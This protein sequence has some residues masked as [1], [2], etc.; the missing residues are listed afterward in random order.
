MISPKHLKFSRWAS[1]GSC[2]FA[3]SVAATAYAFG[4][5]SEGLEDALGYTQE[6]IDFIA[7]VGETGLYMAVFCGVFMGFCGPRLTI[8]LGSILV[9]VGFQYLYLATT[10]Q[11]QSS[12]GSVAGMLF[13]SQLGTACI[14]V[15]TTAVC[16]RNFPPEDRGKAA[17]LAKAY[18]GVSSAIIAQLYAGFFD[19]QT[20]LFLQF[21]SIYI[22]IVFLVSVVQI[23]L[24]PPSLLSY[25][26]ERNNGISTSLDGWFNHLLILVVYILAIGGLSQSFELK[27]WL[28]HALGVGIVLF[29]VAILLLPWMHGP[30]LQRNPGGLSKRDAAAKETSSAPYE[31][32]EYP[33][34]DETN[35][36]Q[37]DK[38]EEAKNVTPVEP[39]EDDSLL[40]C[41]RRSASQKDIKKE[42]LL[43]ES[44]DFPLQKLDRIAGEQDLPVWKAARTTT[45]WTLF[46]LF[47]IGAGSG[48][49]VI[50]NVPQIAESVGTSASSFF[51]SLIGIFNCV[52][53]A[54]I[55]WTSDRVSNFL[56]RPLL[57]TLVIAFMGITCFLFS[58][59]SA[60]L[61]YPCLI[62]TG[63]FYGG[64][65]A[66]MAALAG[67]FFGPSHVAANY[68]ALDLAPACGSFIFATWVVNLFYEDDCDRCFSNTFVVTGAACTVAAIFAFFVLVDRSTKQSLRSMLVRD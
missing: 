65:F 13:V 7:S 36:E 14:S 25:D 8:L 63:F 42:N 51:V 29:Q 68:G 47:I 11:V 34:S 19:D 4:V 43:S 17:G 46:I 61:L 16:I 32:V 64:I 59:G 60:T 30:L 15:T 62:L 66:L 12:V 22:P 5:Y 67:D 52:G 48:L 27:T 53:R 50:N 45:F 49:V 6:D 9:F 54:T 21:L 56:P 26:F 39:N 31:F 33:E 24:L 40:G 38:M 28:T 44:Q 41:F 18:F 35:S 37:A 55:G 23:N 58:I 20:I 3:A 1:L 57:L 2:L 10:E